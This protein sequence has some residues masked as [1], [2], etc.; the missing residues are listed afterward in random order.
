MPYPPQRV[1]Q[2]FEQPQCLAR[3][4][5]PNG[6]TNTFKVFEFR[7]GG[8]WEFVMHG[9]DGSNH[10]NSSVFVQ[11]EAAVKVV[12][13]HVSLPHFILTV[14]LAPHDGGTLIRWVQEFAKSEVAAKQ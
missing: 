7:P 4:W 13:Q 2:A 6:F 1:F 3:W 11:V 10:P 12:I 8:H 9:P 5:G 14:T